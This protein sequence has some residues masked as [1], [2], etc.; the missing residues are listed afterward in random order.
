VASEND[1]AAVRRNACG[2][3]RPA[4]VCFHLG[5]T[6]LPFLTPTPKATDELI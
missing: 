3:P 6:F 4:E 5:A 2:R 1:R